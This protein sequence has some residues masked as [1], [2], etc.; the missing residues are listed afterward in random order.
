[1]RFGTSCECAERCAWEARLCRVLTVCPAAPEVRLPAPVCRVE[2]LNITALFGE[3]EAA[4]L[5]A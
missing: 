1:M 3:D 4:M 5:C 2:L